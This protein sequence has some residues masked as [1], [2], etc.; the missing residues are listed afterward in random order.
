MLQFRKLPWRRLSSPTLPIWTFQQFEKY[1]RSGNWEYGKACAAVERKIARWLRLDP[2]QVIMTSSCTTALATCMQFL[3]KHQGAHSVSLSP[4]TYAATWIWAKNLGLEVVYVDTDDEG[5]PSAS[6]D[7]GVD[8]WGRAFPTERHPLVVLDAAHRCMD[9]RHGELLNSERVQ[10][11]TYSF[12]CQK[13]VPCLHGGALLLSPSAAAMRDD[14]LAFLRC[15][16]RD[17]APLPGVVGT[18]GLLNDPL[19]GWIMSQ[20]RRWTQLHSK[21]RKVIGWYHDQLQRFM[22]TRPDNARGSMAVAIFDS[23][24]ERDLVRRHLERHKVENSVHYPVPPEFQC[25]NAS[26]LSQRLLTLPCHTELQQNDVRRIT[27][28]V[29]SA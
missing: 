14:M 3:F 22:A 23:N 18:K 29:V 16:T 8:L 4:L 28:L 10:A 7:I 15:G 26:A 13:E 11:V 21:R 2:A 20:L 12:N 24:G 1:V 9:V 5:W 19:G 25:P 6:V 17:R 27:R